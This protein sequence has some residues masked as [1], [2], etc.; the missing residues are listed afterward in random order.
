M[1]IKPSPGFPLLKLWSPV[2]T[3]SWGKIWAPSSGLAAS[4]SPALAVHKW[5]TVQVVKGETQLK[6]RRQKEELV[7]SALRDVM[8][9]KEIVNPMTD[10]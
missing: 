5:Q 2:M 3:I 9:E 8:A 6:D 1:P 4:V 10:Q 7:I